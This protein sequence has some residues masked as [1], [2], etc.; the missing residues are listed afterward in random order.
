M[1]N[2]S[3]LL[4]CLSAVVLP[5]SKPARLGEGRAVHLLSDGSFYVFVS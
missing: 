1:R 5:P 2:S 4:A 3:N